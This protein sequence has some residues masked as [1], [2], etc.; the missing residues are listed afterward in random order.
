MIRNNDID[1][2]KINPTGK[3]NRIT[4]EDVLN[5]MSKS[6]SNNQNQ[7]NNESLRSNLNNINSQVKEK[8]NSVKNIG[9]SE[10]NSVADGE[11]VKI[12]G[13]KR[14][15]TKSMTISN[16]IPS[17]L[18]SDEFNVDN[19]VAL[20]KETN[21]LYEKDIKFSYM[22]YIIKATSL[23]L[24]DFPELNSV[25]NP[26]IDQEGYIFEY[27][28]MKNHNISI[29]IDSKNG[30]IVPNIKNVN[31]KSVREIQKELNQLRENANNGKLTNEDFMNGTFSI[32]NIGNIGGKQLNPIIMSPQVCIISLSKIHDSFSVLNKKEL[33][34]VNSSKKMIFTNSDSNMS[35]S[36][37]KS[38]NFCISADHRI[39]DGAYVAKFSEKLRHLIENP[40][41]ILLG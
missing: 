21:D 16:S 31:K 14:E 26:N 3:D 35:V 30:L 34:E 25:I 8:I 2:R 4:K 36:F 28:I 7:I 1:W 13:I 12:F 33:N 10:L 41:K 17:F 37:N 24:I 27:T 23:A 38:I 22:P 6:Q 32:S 40:L 11:T 18:Y 20:R 19:L 9:K 29:A 15:M 39:I 5:F